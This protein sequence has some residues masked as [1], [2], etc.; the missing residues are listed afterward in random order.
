MMYGESQDTIASREK[1]IGTILAILEST[2]IKNISHAKPRTALAI[3]L[4]EAGCRVPSDNE[5]NLALA[6]V[7]ERIKKMG[8][9][10][11]L[12]SKLA[13]PE[14]KAHSDKGVFISFEQLDELERIAQKGYSEPKGDAW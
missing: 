10:A 12:H 13:S 2:N 8:C 14:V 7:I 1:A 5:C 4:Y 11:G 9:Y 6:V 3:A